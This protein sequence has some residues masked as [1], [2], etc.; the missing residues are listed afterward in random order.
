MLIYKIFRQSEWDAL[1][2]TGQTAGAPIDLTDGYIHFSTRETVEE[3]AA[4]HFATETDLILAA[5]D[6]EDLGD[7]LKWEISRGGIK[8]PHLYSKL[9]HSD[10]K[11]HAALPKSADG[12]NF[13]GLL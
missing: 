3:T 4:K 6:A 12:F 5:V 13:E 9:K 1:V 10:V 2:A 8:F 7:A 11:S